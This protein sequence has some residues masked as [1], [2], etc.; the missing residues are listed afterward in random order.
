MRWNWWRRLSR[1]SDLVVDDQ[2]GMLALLHP[3]CSGRLDQGF[4]SHRVHRSTGCCRTD[5][6]FFPVSSTIS[7]LVTVSSRNAVGLSGRLGRTRRRCDGTGLEPS[8]FG[9]E[10]GDPL[11][12]LA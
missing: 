12:Q 6:R 2:Q 8:H 10:G 3:V 7:T 1:T 9:L 4:G 11:L 5:T